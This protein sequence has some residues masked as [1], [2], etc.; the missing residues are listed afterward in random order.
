MAQYGNFEE[1]S[2][3]EK[4]HQLFYSNTYEDE[5]MTDIIRNCVSQPIIINLQA[6]NLAPQM[7][8]CPLVAHIPQPLIRQ[9]NAKA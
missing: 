5:E 3:M 8:S 2:N 9:G 1:V 6:S 4:E 7:M